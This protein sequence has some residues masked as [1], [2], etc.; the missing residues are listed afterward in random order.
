MGDS[1]TVEVTCSIVSG[2]LFH[3]FRLTGFRVS[4]V[5]NKYA[6]W[7]LS[8]TI[9]SGSVLAEDDLVGLLR[10]DLKLQKQAFMEVSM[11]LTPDEGR[12]F[13]PVYREYVSEYELIGDQQLAL[14]MEF[15]AS[16]GQLTNERAREMVKM[17]LELDRQVIVLRQRYFDRVAAELSAIIAARF[18]Q[19]D[20]QI[21]LLAEFKL[22]NDLPLV[23]P[24]E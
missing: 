23:K 15:G 8:Y 18:L 19:V 5:M 21:T 10:H 3:L 20:S 14:I 22:A 16:Q 13:W 4:F 12:I 7:L 17:T 11:E 24:L 6:I 2:L 1:V 9:L